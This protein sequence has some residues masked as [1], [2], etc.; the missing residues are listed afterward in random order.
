MADRGANCK[1]LHVR[2][3]NDSKH[4]WGHLV[5]THDCDCQ[6]TDCP[7]GCTK[8]EETPPGPRPGC[9]RQKQVELLLD[10]DAPNDSN[11]Q[12]ETA[13]ECRIPVPQPKNIGQE[14]LNADCVR[15]WNNMRSPKTDEEDRKI[16]RPNPEN[17]TNIE[18]FNVDHAGDGFFT[19]DQ[20]CDQISTKTCT[21]KPNPSLRSES[22][23]ST[24]FPYGK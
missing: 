18:R 7:Y 12:P 23:L 19:R 1:I 22:S 6:L 17:P 16:K 9:Q 10:V 2:D 4:P 21:P 5:R 11:P 20:L 13:V 15:V 14:S 24:V 3:C 8:N